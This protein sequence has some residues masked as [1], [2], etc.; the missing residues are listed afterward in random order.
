M[1]CIYINIYYINPARSRQNELYS[2]GEMWVNKLLLLL[3]L[4]YLICHLNKYNVEAGWF[5]NANA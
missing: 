1:K 2:F 5:I 3:L 4:Q